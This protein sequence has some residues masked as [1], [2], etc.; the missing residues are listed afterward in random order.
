[1]K[2]EIPDGWVVVPRGG[3]PP[4]HARNV[5]VFLALQ[6]RQER[7]REKRHQAIAWA[8]VKWPELGDE[9]SVQRAVNKAKGA[10]SLYG[11]VINSDRFSMFLDSHPALWPGPVPVGATGWLWVVGEKEAVRVR[12]TK[13]QR[14]IAFQQTY[15]T[16]AV[17]DAWGV[18]ETVSATG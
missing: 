13:V 14:S 2:S 11:V 9:R 6:W 4:K 5:A 1:M 16:W 8:A 3:R 15:L 7:E 12:A 10:I 18:A 17:R